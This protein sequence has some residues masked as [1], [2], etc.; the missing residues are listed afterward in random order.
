M[1]LIP[2]VTPTAATA[3]R[4]RPIPSTI[5][6]APGVFTA[7][8][9]PQIPTATASELKGADPAAEPLHV[10]SSRLDTFPRSA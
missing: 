4:F 8:A 9:V 7:S 3:L 6:S 10:I 5:P 2:P 1:I